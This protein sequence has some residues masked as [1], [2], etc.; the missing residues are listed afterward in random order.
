MRIEVRPMLNQEIH[1]DYRLEGKTN[2]LHHTPPAQETS[3]DT[4]DDRW[5]LKVAEWAF[6]VADYFSYDRDVVAI[7][8]NYIDRYMVFNPETE[9]DPRTCKRRFQLL[10][11]T[12]LYIAMKL[13]GDSSD[14][15]CAGRKPSIKLFVSLS[16]HMFEPGEIERM[17][18][19]ILTN[20]RWR[21]NPPLSSTFVK[22]FIDLFPAWHTVDPQECRQV[23]VRLHETARYLTEMS[24]CSSDFSFMFKPSVIGYAAVLASIDAL[25][26]EPALKSV[27][28]PYHII[29]K[30][31]HDSYSETSLEPSSDD[32]DTAR[33]ML[34]DICPNVFPSNATFLA[35]GS[36]FQRNYLHKQSVVEKTT[37]DKER[38]SPTDILSFDAEIT[39]PKKRVEVSLA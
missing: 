33:R 15:S 32:V 37:K 2:Y 9:N 22:Y 25:E 28:P 39:T 26:R 6:E 20:L 34:I 30:F 8:L 29:V 12:A 31:I 11:L 10:T 21:V 24:T 1:P 7:S 35:K 18:L 36:N 17:E 14:A 3:S 4:I 13:H 16:R 38:S 5:R 19:N 23:K 27:F